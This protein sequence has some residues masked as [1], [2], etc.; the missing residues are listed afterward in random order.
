MVALQTSKF[1]ESQPA[2]TVFTH[3]AEMALQAL[4]ADE[5]SIVLSPVCNPLEPRVMLDFSSASHGLWVLTLAMRQ[6]LRAEHEAAAALCLKL[7]MRSCK[8]L[9]EVKKI[10]WVKKGLSA[11]DLGT[12]GKLG[13]VLPALESLVLRQSSPDPSC[14]QRL[15]EG[16]I[17]GA[18]PSVTELI[19]RHV[20]VSDACASALAAAMGRGALPQLKSLQ[21]SGNG[22]SRA[23]LSRAGL[24][25]LVP[26]LLQRPALE[27]LILYGNPF[28]DEG[29]A[30]LLAP[31]PAGALPPPTE[32]STKLKV[33]HLDLSFTQITDTGCAALTAA[34]ESGA[35]PLLEKLDLVGINAG[36]RAAHGAAV[37]LRAA[38]AKRAIQ[39]L[40]D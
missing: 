16:L 22:L 29:L 34:L 28:G 13:L 12:L 27:K 31:P 1:W 17:V 35:L 26:A 24:V 30:A 25:A 39:V 32:V 6:Q 18:L 21:L 11:A 37:A 8:E 23:G 36:V 9:R 15:A 33:K 3:G 10:D 2:P 14:V 20:V 5:L 4:C 38:L 7:G 19:L 40:K